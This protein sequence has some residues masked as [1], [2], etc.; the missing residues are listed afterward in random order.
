MDTN[1]S[2]KPELIIDYLDDDKS[3]WS[4]IIFKIKE[5]CNI[6]QAEYIAMKIVRDFGYRRKDDAHVPNPATGYSLT[7][8]LYEYLNDLCQCEDC[9]N[10]VQIYRDT[11]DQYYFQIT[12]AN[13]YDKEGKYA[14]TDTVKVWFKEFIW[15]A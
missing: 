7:D 5:L 10:G 8:D 13:F 9:K 11:D 14:G 3:D 6:E 15:K 12:G 4:D 2:T 1:V